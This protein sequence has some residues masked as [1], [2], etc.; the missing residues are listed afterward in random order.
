MIS[1]FIFLLLVGLIWG[2][3]CSIFL[4][5]LFIYLFILVRWF[6][7]LKNMNKK[8]EMFKLS[9]YS[10]DLQNKWGIIL[11]LLVDIICNYADPL[12]FASD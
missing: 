8:F 5:L 2:G 3:L 9:L 7:W 6:I 1:M 12:I 4:I 11:E 10:I